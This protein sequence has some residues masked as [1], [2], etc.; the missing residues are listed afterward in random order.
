[1]TSAADS[2]WN[3]DRQD[4]FRSIE[5]LTSEASDPSRI[6]VS[7]DTI[8]NDLELYDDPRQGAG[9]WLYDSELDLADRL[10]V[11]LH[12]AILDATPVEAGAAALASREWGNV[13]ATAG[14]LQRLM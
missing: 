4:L 7:L 11:Q 2:W 3:E 14:A 13:Q 8:L 10:G 6:G 12:D 9:A 5:A 1:M